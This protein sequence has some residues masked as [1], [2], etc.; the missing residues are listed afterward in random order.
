[1]KTM[2]KLAL[3]GGALLAGIAANAAELQVPATGN[4]SL[5]FYVAD[6]TTKQT[7]T[8]LLPM[9]SVAGG[10]INVNGAATA[11]GP[12]Y[13]TAADALSSSTQG[14]VNPIF[15]DQ[16]FSYTLSGDTG[17]QNFLT[18]ASNAVD[19]VG[20]GIYA[21]GYNAVA[22]DPQ[23][24]SLMI[25]TGTAGGIV[26]LSDTTVTGGVVTALAGDYG[27]LNTNYASHKDSFAAAPGLPGPYGVFGT[28]AQSNA[29]TLMGAGMLTYQTIGAAAVELYGVTGNG[30]A[31]GNA[32]AFGLGQ[33]S[34]NGTALSFTG[35]QAAVPIPGAAWLLGS[36]L[37]GL[38]GIG[39]RRERALEA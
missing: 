39:R 27:K 13:F 4:G 29:L 22:P 5:L 18:A 3:G 28:S 2:L 20:W 9:Q 30:T 38:L 16:N 35:N 33:I 10:S 37:L 34:F 8:L 32:L 17:L 23:G 31:S 26:G 21:L 24:A 19:T 36:G 1:M 25:T 14:V 6:L 15:G 7:Y 12:G 11:T